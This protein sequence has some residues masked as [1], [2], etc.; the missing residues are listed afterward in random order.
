MFLPYDS[1]ESPV[2]CEQILCRS[3]RRF[4]SNEGI[5]QGYPLRNHYFTAV[6]LS[7]VRTVADRHRLAAYHNK[8]CWR[9]FQWYQHRWP[10]MTLNSKNR[11]FKW[12]FVV[13]CCKTHFKSEMRRNHWRQTKHTDT[14]YVWNLMLSR[15]S[16]ALAQVSCFDTDS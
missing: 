14:T 1:V 5:K 9:A 16:R 15:V 8:H 11:R 10:W 13:L 7:S 12:F 3:V 2:S 6:N 4:P